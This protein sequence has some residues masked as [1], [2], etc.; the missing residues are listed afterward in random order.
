MGPSASP[1]DGEA[2]ASRAPT[3]PVP[4]HA[5]RQ[6]DGVHINVQARTAM[7][8]PPKTPNI[9]MMNGPSL[10]PHGQSPG[11]PPGIQGLGVSYRPPLLDMHGHP[12][13]TPARPLSSGFDIPT[14]VSNSATLSP[15]QYWQHQNGYMSGQPNPSHQNNG[16]HNQAI[17]FTPQAPTYHPPHNPYMNTIHQHRP[18]SAQSAHGFQS[19]VKHQH[20]ASSPPPPTNGHASHSPFPPAS[21]PNASFPPPPSQPAQHP[22]I[23]QASSPPRTYQAPAGYT[24]LGS[25]PGYSPT[26]SPPRPASGHG[27]SGT[28]VVPPATTL[29]P[30]TDRRQQR[31]SLEPP[32][33]K[34]MTPERPQANGYGNPF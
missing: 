18:P 17:A 16:L 10:S 32:A 27:V 20:P 34:M 30:S 15:L 11:P 19:P 12:T 23:E 33:K 13:A 9:V 26:K 28:P 7:S 14:L 8:P 29:S 21:S 1:K 31:L 25:T 24:L 6:L 5:P 2:E 3:R 4:A 22:P